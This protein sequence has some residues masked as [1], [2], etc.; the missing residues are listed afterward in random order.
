MGKIEP[1]EGLAGSGPVPPLQ[2][3]LANS[4]SKLMLS[5]AM[6]RSSRPL[7]PSCPEKHII[8]KRRAE[9]GIVAVRTLLA[10]ALCF[11]PGL[12]LADGGVPPIPNTPA[13]SALASWLDAFDSGDR[14]RLESF[15][16]SHASWATL[17][18]EMKLLAKTGGYDLLS[19]D[20]S[21]KLWISFRLKQRATAD[22]GH[23]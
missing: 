21:E 15:N 10:V 7:T 20:K 4:K 3:Q 9:E 17:D 18:R 8:S 2:R 6:P 16:K 12:A 14:A 23:R 5:Q 1:D 22:T 19:I 11:S 13:G